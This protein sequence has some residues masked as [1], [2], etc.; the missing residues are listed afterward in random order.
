MGS[1]AW[2]PSPPVDGN[3]IHLPRDLPPLRILFLYPDFLNVY[4]DRGNLTALVQR[5]RW[6]GLP[7]TVTEASVGTPVDATRFDLVLVGGGQDRAQ[8][9]VAED[10]RR[11]K[12]PSLIEAVEDG[13]PVLAICGGYQLMGHFYRTAEGAEMKGLGLFDAWTEAGGRRMIGNVAVRA[14]LGDARPLVVGFENHSGRTTL[15]ARARP[16]GRVLYGYGNNGSDGTEGA[17]YRNAIGTYLHGS[18][19]PKN[20]TLADWLLQAAV[21]RRYGQGIR[22]PPLDDTVEHQAR[23]ATLRKLLGPPLLRGV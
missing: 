8:Q 14:E 21:D 6:R 22:L 18:L 15:G 12:G 19:L 3:G 4:G 5:A 23:E 2:P 10:F 11:S 16:L 9:A 13:C 1:H 20:P 7:T 17:R